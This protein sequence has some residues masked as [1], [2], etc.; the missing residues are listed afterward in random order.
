[1]GCMHPIISIQGLNKTYADGFQALKSVDLEV[2]R[3]EIFGLLGPNGA[4]KTTLISTICGIT[5]PSSG[6]ITVGGH[7]TQTAF[8]AARSRSAA[9]PMS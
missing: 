2:D 1:M 4:G 7:D 3:G 9:R 5:V 8:R 6:T